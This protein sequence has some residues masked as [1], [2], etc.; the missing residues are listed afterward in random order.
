MDSELHRHRAFV[1][2]F[3]CVR[4]CGYRGY[5]GKA[6]TTGISGSRL[7]AGIAGKPLRQGVFR[8]W[9]EFSL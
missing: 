5:C 6:I 4:A 8:A 9:T 2:A 1:R 3:A 7:S